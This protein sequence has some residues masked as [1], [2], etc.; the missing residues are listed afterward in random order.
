MSL[1]KLNG[2]LWGELFA[3]P[4]KLGPEAL[5][6]NLFMSLGKLNGALW[7]EHIYRQVSWLALELVL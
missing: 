2:V 1:D 3:V 4:A 6:D 7:G 5:K